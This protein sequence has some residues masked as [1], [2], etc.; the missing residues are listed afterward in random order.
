MIKAKQIADLVLGYDIIPKV[1]TERIKKL[2]KQPPIYDGLWQ[3][4][5]YMCAAASICFVYKI[6]WSD[7]FA[8]MVLGMSA[9]VLSQWKALGA[10]YS[11]I[12]GFILITM[13]IMIH[14][15]I[16]PINIFR[17]TIAGIAMSCRYKL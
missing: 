2:M 5:A 8:A 4:M 14:N 3:I 12:G 15:L 7:L 1:G 13:S 6:G 16:H 17:V 9:G 11:I 10:A